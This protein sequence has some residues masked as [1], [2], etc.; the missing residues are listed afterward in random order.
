M[1]G[2]TERLTLRRA[3]YDPDLDA[4]SLHEVVLPGVSVQG[5]TAFLPGKTGPERRDI[6]K[7]RVPSALCR[8]YLAPH[9]WTVSPGDV[10]VYKGV[11]Y[12]VCTVHNDLERRINPHVYLELR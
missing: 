2:C 10:A 11:E 9:G 1:L 5:A 6:L 3:V 7:V 4:D 12:T 8:D